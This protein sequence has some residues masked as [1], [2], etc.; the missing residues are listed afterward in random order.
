MTDRLIQQ[1]D[2]FRRVYD[3]RLKRLGRWG[4][5]L[6]STQLDTLLSVL[7]GD[8]VLNVD[9]EWLVKAYREEE[10]TL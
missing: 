5:R 3:D 7:A 1:R 4:H 9:F 6:T 10:V 8:T 2:G